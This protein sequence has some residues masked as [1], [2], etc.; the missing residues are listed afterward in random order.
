M[1]YNCK[2]ITLHVG[3]KLSMRMLNS[4]YRVVLLLLTFFIYILKKKKDTAFNGISPYEV[5]MD[6]NFFFFF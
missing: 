3:C 1:E 4:E 5:K 2:S 6:N